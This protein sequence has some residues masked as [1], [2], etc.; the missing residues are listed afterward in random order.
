M[1]GRLR[2]RHRRAPYAYGCGSAARSRTSRTATARSSFPFAGLQNGPADGLCARHS[3]DGVRDA[4][5]ARLRRQRSSCVS[6]A[7]NGKHRR[8]T[9][10]VSETKRRRPRSALSLQLVGT[11]NHYSV[12]HVAGLGDRVGGA[13]QHRPDVPVSERGG[14]HGIATHWLLPL[15]LGVACAGGPDLAPEPIA[16]VATNAPELLAP[17]VGAFT[18]RVTDANGAPL[19]AARV[20]RI[21][22]DRVVAEVRCGGDGTFV[23][24]GVPPGRSSLRALAD[25]FAPGQRG[26]LDAMDD[27]GRAIDVG[28]FVLL[29]ATPYRGRRAQRRP[30]P[31]RRPRAGA[32]RP[33][34]RRPD[35]AAR[36]RGDHRRRR[37]VLRAGRAAAAGPGAGARRRARAHRGAALR[38]LPTPTSSSNSSPRP[39]SPARWSTPSTAPRCRTPT[40]T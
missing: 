13:A 32:P 2:R 6:G 5:P 9:I 39:R 31:R 28:A 19:P 14:A 11:G 29:P 3:T 36:P 7:A 4:V 22:G 30:R 34:G 27:D 8:P 26:D 37:L 35:G 10:G 17:P 25:G 16:P 33:A 18:G 38:T 15:L 21:D 24:G 40:C 23:L 20:Q 12:V 1:L